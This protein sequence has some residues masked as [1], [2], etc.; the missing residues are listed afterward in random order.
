VSGGGFDKGVREGGASARFSASAR[1][2]SLEIFS[3]GADPILRHDAGAPVS[4]VDAVYS[5]KQGDLVAVEY[6]TRIGRKLVED[7]VVLAVPGAAGAGAAGD[8]GNAKA[9]ATGAKKDQP[10]TQPA[11]PEVDEKA[12]NAAM[13]KG[14]DLMRRKKWKLAAQAY[15]DVFKV[16]ADDPEAQLGLAGAQAEAKDRAASVATLLKLAYSTHPDAPIFLVAARSDPHLADLRTDEGYRRA[17]GLVPDPKRQPSAYERLVGLG[18]HWEQPPVPCQE[19]QVN[20]KLAY[21]KKQTFTL[22]IRSTCQ[23]QGDNT[24]LAGNWSASGTST[25]ELVFPN[26]DG[27]EEKVSCRLEVCRDNSGEDCLRCQPEANLEFL[28]RVVRR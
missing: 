17:V 8:R 7:A 21:G 15:T 25:L 27:P 26:T 16:S 14:S 23:G 19:P 9:P 1:G 24:L 28:L 3:S 5:R 18:G 10:P 11:R 4:Q 12:R 20:L 13:K 2:N 22:R 6:H